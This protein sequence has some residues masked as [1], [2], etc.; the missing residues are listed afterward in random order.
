[1]PTYVFK[2]LGN[3]RDLPNEIVVTASDEPKAR[4][5]AMWQR[6]GAPPRTWGLPYRY[7]GVGLILLEVKP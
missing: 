7:K 2:T 4:E 6:W 5:K 3:V 1:M